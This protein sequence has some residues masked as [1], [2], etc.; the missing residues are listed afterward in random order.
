M[1]VCVCVCVCVC[2]GLQIIDNYRYVS[3]INFPLCLDQD[4][5]A[6]MSPRKRVPLRSSRRPGEEGIQPFQPE[7]DAWQPV[8]GHVMT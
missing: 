5:P 8:L 1:C 7:T 6:R 2:G 3:I 4:S